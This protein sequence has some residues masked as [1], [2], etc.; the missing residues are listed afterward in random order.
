MGNAADLGE[1]VVKNQVSGQV[2]GRS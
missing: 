2:G 1:F